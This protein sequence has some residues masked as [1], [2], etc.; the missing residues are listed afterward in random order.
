MKKQVTGIENDLLCLA[1]SIGSSISRRPLAALQDAPTPISSKA[2]DILGAASA[3]QRRRLRI[4][5]RSHGLRPDWPCLPSLG[6]PCGNTFVGMVL[7]RLDDYLRHSPTMV[8][9]RSR[10][11]SCV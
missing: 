8:T 3:S 1:W 2:F 6:D 4:S 10:D 9:L 7:N 11:G 5:D